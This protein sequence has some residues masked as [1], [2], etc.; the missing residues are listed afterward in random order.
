MSTQ[1][2]YVTRIDNDTPSAE[3]RTGERV[4][5]FL[6]DYVGNIGQC[7]F[8]NDGRHLA[9]PNFF[10]MFAVYLYG[11]EP[12]WLCLKC[13]SQLYVQINLRQMWRRP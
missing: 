12:K 6:I 2:P 5:L 10:F 4:P 7:F 11:D 9:A 8:F 1:D 13:V 3:L